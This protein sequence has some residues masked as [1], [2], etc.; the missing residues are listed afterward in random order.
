[1]ST[2]ALGILLR[3][4]RERSE[5]SLRELGDRADLDH[6]YIY[7]LETGHK[8]APSTD[9]TARLARALELT[10]REREIL[11]CVAER[12]GTDPRLAEL[13]A[14]DPTIS[15]EE[16]FTAAGTTFRGRA[17]PDPRTMIERARRMLR[18]EADD[19]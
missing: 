2:T 16:F 6:A 4:L 18:D 13:A 10:T 15:S 17:R 3:H 1:M 14:E 7:R 5:L 11:E 9:V 12:P 8:V 19:G